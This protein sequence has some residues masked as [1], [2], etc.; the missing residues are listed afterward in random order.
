MQQCRCGMRLRTPF[1]PDGSTIGDICPSFSAVC[2]C[3]VC[4][5]T[6]VSLQMS[7]ESTCSFDNALDVMPR[8]QPGIVFTKFVL[9]STAQATTE[10]VPHHFSVT[11]STE[12]HPHPAPVLPALLQ[13]ALIAQHPVAKPSSPHASA[14]MFSYCTCGD[15]QIDTCTIYLRR[16]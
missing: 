5:F 11:A 12:H 15:V 14:V 4:C 2:T 16:V 6:V 9:V 1:R 10:C 3:H 13:A 7:A 8:N